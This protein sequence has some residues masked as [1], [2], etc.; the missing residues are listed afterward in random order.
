MKI[1]CSD[2]DGTFNFGGIDESKCNAIKKWQAAGNKFG[3]VSG[4]PASLIKEL[5]SAYPLVFDFYIAHNGAVIL[6]RQNNLLSVSPCNSVS[7]P[8]LLQNLFAWGCEFAHI[9]NENYYR[10]RRDDKALGAEEYRLSTLPDIPYFYQVSV[11]LESVEQAK[12][13]AQKAQAQYENELS[14]LQNGI[15]VDIVRK[16]INKTHGIYQIAKI[17]HVQRENIIAVGDNVNDVDMLQEFPSYAM[18][19]GTLE[20]KTA[21]NRTVRS[22][23]DLIEKEL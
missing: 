6:D 8:Q 15:C 2:Y 5:Q 16:G 11:Q 10:V 21:A 20:A 17:F 4:R 3:L 23:V 14:A 12:S 19:N 9:N 18:E 1:L 22:I 13:V 7:L